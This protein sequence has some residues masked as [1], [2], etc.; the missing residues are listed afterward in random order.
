MSLTGNQGSVVSLLVI[1]DYS[2]T[3]AILALISDVYPK[4]ILW[5]YRYPGFGGLALGLPGL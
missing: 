5:Y 1:P 2:D 3:E 4:R